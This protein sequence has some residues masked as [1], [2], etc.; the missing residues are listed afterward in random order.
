MSKNKINRSIANIL[1][2]RAQEQIRNINAENA[3][4][5]KA[6][7]EKSKDYKEYLKLYAQKLELSK[8]INELESKIEEENS[9]SAYSITIHNYCGDSPSFSTRVGYPSA[10]EIADD[11][12]LEAHF[13]DSDMSHEDLLKSIVA[14]HI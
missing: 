10:N 4:K 8:K 12:M 11:I 3:E 9:T 7:V 13:A 1:A 14:K 2:Y 6:A 5:A